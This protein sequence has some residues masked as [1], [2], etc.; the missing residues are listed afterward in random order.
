MVAWIIRKLHEAVKRKPLTGAGGGMFL[1]GGAFLSCAFIASTSFAAPSPPVEPGSQINLE[2]VPSAHAR[3]D[4]GGDGAGGGSA[5]E[6]GPSIPG[7]GLAA[8]IEKQVTA[9]I[10]AVLA[11][12]MLD[13]GQTSAVIVH[14]YRPRPAPYEPM[15]QSLQAQATGSNIVVR[16]ANTGM[17][18]T[19]TLSSDDGVKIVVDPGETTRWVPLGGMQEWDFVITGLK[20]GRHDLRADV[21]Y[22]LRSKAETSQQ[23][24]SHFM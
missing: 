2:D 14:V 13:V 6:C 10:G 4:V 15:L 21:A 19:A 7:D 9:G 23:T 22:E 17:S 5:G 3:T 20:P 16:P 1:L 18:M 11:P 8:A 24:S 12:E